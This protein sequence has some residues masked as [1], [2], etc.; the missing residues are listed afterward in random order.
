[1][2]TNPLLLTGPRKAAIVATRADLPA[3]EPDE[4]LPPESGADL[5]YE[6]VTER[7]ERITE[8]FYRPAVRKVA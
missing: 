4:V 6:R 7:G 5:L 1:M 3:R 8:R 2:S